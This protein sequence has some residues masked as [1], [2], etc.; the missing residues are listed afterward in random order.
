TL[1]L[2]DMRPRADWIGK[3][4]RELRLR[5]RYDINVVAIR[6]KDG[7]AAHMNPAKPLRQDS[8]L[9][10]VTEKSNLGKLEAGR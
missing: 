10:V 2:I 6:E 7:L 9:L 3:N 5:E 4:L 1:C 8:T